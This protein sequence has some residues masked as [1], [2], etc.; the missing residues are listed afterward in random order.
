MS[1]VDEIQIEWKTTQDSGT[2]FYAGIPYYHILP[3]FGQ[4]NIYSF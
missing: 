1:S 2:I 4:F 3:I